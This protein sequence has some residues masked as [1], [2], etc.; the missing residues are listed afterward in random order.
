M[1]KTEKL[2]IPYITVE[3]INNRICTALG[4]HNRRLETEERKWLEKY[5]EKHNLGYTAYPKLEEAVM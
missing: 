4:R 2:D 5:A 1:R 3:V